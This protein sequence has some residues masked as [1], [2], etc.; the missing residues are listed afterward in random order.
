MQ[1]N[2]LPINEKLSVIKGQEGSNI[3]G[4]KKIQSVS[5]NLKHQNQMVAIFKLLLI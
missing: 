3:L 1:T 2:L 5:L 4:L